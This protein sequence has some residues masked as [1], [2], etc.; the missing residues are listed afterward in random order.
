M[1]WVPDVDLFL[2]FLKCDH[3]V[4]FSYSAMRIDHLYIVC[5]IAIAN[6]NELLLLH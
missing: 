5:W 2:M 6:V 1:G 4:H 3:N